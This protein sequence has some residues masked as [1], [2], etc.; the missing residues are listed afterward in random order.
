MLEDQSEL[1]Q[2]AAIYAYDARSGETKRK[3]RENKKS[4]KKRK[5]LELDANSL[6][7]CFL[8]RACIYDISV[9]GFDLSRFVF[10]SQ[11]GTQRY[12]ELHTISTW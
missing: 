3:K 4:K 10:E 11:I 5:R 9:V 7:V 6:S 8:M 1:D 12:K 2:L